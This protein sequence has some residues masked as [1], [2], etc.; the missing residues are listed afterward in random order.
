LNL[1]GFSRPP[2][3]RRSRTP[4]ELQSRQLAV[5]ERD[6]IAFS[7]WFPLGGKG[8]PKHASLDKIARDTGAT[9]TQIALAWRLAQL[10]VHGDGGTIGSIA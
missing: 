2:V 1:L 5:C 4:P 8:M 9:P 7:A 10:C 3:S 6:G